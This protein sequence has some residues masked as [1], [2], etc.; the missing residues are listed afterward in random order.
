MK[1]VP[2]AAQILDVRR[3]QKLDIVAQL[4]TEQAR[5]RLEV[6]IGK[7]PPLSD[8]QMWSELHTKAIEL[9]DDRRLEN[10]RAFANIFSDMLFGLSLF[11][12]LYANPNQVSQS[13]AL[14]LPLS[15]FIPNS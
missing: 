10:R 4:K 1:K 5:M 2:L 8:D 12:L 14:S 11:L 3:E 15:L 7:S 13:L 9:R 6:Q